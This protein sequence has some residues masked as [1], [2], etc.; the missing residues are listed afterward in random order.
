MPKFYPPFSL[1]QELVS[2]G[3]RF[4]HDLTSNPFNTGEVGGDSG[5]R[6]VSC[7]TVKDPRYKVPSHIGQDD[8]FDE[9]WLVGFGPC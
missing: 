1:V 4:E 6:V 8:S 7:Y 9:G 3:L 2:V 5:S